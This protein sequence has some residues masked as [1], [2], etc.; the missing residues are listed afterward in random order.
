M[1]PVKA[2]T[3]RGLATADAQKVLVPAAL[4]AAVDQEAEHYFADTKL[5][6]VQMVAVALRE[7]LDMRKRLQEEKQTK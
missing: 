2:Q 7:W 5:S 1:S 3:R 4:L 6:R